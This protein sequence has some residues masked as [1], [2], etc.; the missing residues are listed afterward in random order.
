MYSV[1]GNSPGFYLIFSENCGWSPRKGGMFNKT[2][3][4][5]S[6]SISKPRSA[7]ISSPGS[8]NFM[9]PQSFVNRLSDVLP[10][11]SSD[12]KVKSLLGEMPIKPLPVLWFV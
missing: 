11:Y 4:G 8:N 6:S 9:M 1:F 7:I 10:G 3:G 5:K 12:T 2:P